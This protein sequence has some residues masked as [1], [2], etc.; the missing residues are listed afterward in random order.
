MRKSGDTTI[1]NL[2]ELAT[3]REISATDLLQRVPG[4]STSQGRYSFRG[5][6][7]AKVLLDGIDL[8]DG[9]QVDLTNS[10]DYNKVSSIKLVEN[11]NP[12]GVLDLDF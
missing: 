5:V 12:H 8:D 2:S 1:L 6:P 9:N 10:V 4:M 3:G 11:Y 7:I